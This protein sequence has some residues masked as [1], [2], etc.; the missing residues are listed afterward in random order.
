MLDIE[1][2]VAK[3]MSN[4]IPRK[5]K[6]G[7]LEKAE[8]GIYPGG[9]PVGYKLDRETRLHTFDDKKAHH[10]KK[11][12][13]LIASGS[14]SMEMTCDVLFKDGLRSKKDTRLGTGALDKFIKNPFYYGFFRF[15]EKIYQ[16]SHEAL[17]SKELFDKT[18]RA[19]SGDH[20]P[21][22]G[23][24]GFAFNNLLLCG[25]CGCRILGEQ[26]KIRYNYYHCTFS[27]GRHQEVG[28]IPENRL[29]GMFE[30]SVRSAT[31]QDLIHQWLKKLV[32][33]ASQD[34][35]KFQDNRLSG[36]QSQLKQ[37]QERLNKLFDLKLDGTINDEM[38]KFKYNE[39][40]ESIALIKSQIKQ[41]ERINPNFYE[42]GLKTLE[43]CKSLYPEY[44]T[45]NYDGKADILKK[46]ASNYIINDVTLYPTWKK[47]FDLM[48]KGLSHSVKLPES[49]R[50]PNFFYEVILG[51]TNA[52][53][54]DRWIILN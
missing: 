21:Y 13:E 9:S 51:L 10:I 40:I 43:L 50:N 44:V 48:A 28:Y 52:K 23:K 19:L 26:K 18:Q 15:K 45:R 24:M 39:L 31:L 54:G 3:K 20:R 7:M 34:R 49:P 16:G 5:T 41:A 35:A 38:F 32:W 12:F 2:A 4:D 36:L 8:Q 27:K 37:A 14:Y 33:E 1:V 17:I 47:P 22:K 29:A 11:A 46:L 42:D 30:P 53:N 25:H 6:M